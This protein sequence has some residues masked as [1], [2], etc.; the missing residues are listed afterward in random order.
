MNR[1]DL[2]RQLEKIW[3]SSVRVYSYRS[4]PK[5]VWKKRRLGAYMLCRLDEGTGCLQVNGS[6]VSFEKGDWILLHPGT[7][8]EGITQSLSPARLTLLLFSCTGLRKG[9]EGWQTMQP[10]LPLEGKLTVK[11]DSLVMKDMTDQLV[12]RYKN[13]DAE[14]GMTL[15]YLLSKLL[16]AFIKEKVTAEDK[17]ESV[18]GLE[19]ALSY[20]HNHFMNDIS[21]KQLAE[22]ASFSVNHFTR[23][24]K[25]QLNRTPTEYLLELRMAKAK[26]LLISQKKMKKVAEQV[27]FQDEH[28]FSR[29]F[30]KSQGVAPTLYFKNKCHRIGAL[31]YGLD[32]HL[33]TLGLQPVTFL[34]YAERVSTTSIEPGAGHGQ[35]TMRLSSFA[36]NYDNLMRTKSDLLLTSDRLEKDE[37]ISLIAPTVTLSHFDNGG[38]VLEQMAALLGKEQQAA[39]WIERYTERKEELSRAIHKRWGK[40]NAYFIRVSSGYYRVYGS[41]NQTGSLLYDDLGL[42]VPSPNMEG[43]WAADISLEEVPLYNADHLFLMVDP[44][45]EARVRLKE[46]VESEQWAAIDAVRSNRVHDAGDLMFKALGSSGRMG[47]MSRIAAQLGL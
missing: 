10:Q 17:R 36:P 7:I 37:T 24:F 31:Y 43:K 18:R 22:L 1:S 26:Q 40:Q 25:Q 13:R 11:E 46:L 16:M 6:V 5:V 45:E 23:V 4:M 8:V 44:T 27:G 12:V 30:K 33:M 3:F 28:Y 41:R 39:E 2:V 20:M 42:S 47:A 9:P 19:R 15:K 29:A 32:E 14:T 35:G 34:S 21:V 38:K